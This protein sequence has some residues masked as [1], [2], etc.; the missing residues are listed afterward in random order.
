MLQHTQQ[1]KIMLGSAGSFE[2]HLASKIAACRKFGQLGGT[3]F[4]DVG[5]GTPVVSAPRIG[6]S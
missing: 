2:V 5:N 4:D 6:F 1:G 3:K